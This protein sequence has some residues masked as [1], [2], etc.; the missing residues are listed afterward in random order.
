MAFLNA[1]GNAG[2]LALY[3]AAQM[4]DDADA[5]QRMFELIDARMRE[6]AA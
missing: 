1:R 4:S 6:D 5:A 3:L 2:D